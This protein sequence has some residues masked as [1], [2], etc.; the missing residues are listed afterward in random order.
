MSILVV[1]GFICDRL[2]AALFG[3]GLLCNDLLR[4]LWHEPHGWCRG[5]SS[6]ELVRTVSF[7]SFS[8]P[9]P[10]VLNERLLSPKTSQS[11]IRHMQVLDRDAIPTTP[12]QAQ[13][14]SGNPNGYR[15]RRI[16][17]LPRQL[18]RQILI[19]TAGLRFEHW[20]HH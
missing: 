20:L 2:I 15:R 6:T 14:G 16:P 12:C 17:S 10:L 19:M 7:A 18:L 3:L 1:I 9:S 13:S 8:S 11:R 4:W 5:A